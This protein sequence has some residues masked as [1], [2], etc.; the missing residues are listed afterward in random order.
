MKKTGSGR[1][2]CTPTFIAAL[3]TIDRTWKQ[4]KCPSTDQWV[5][6]A[7]YTYIPAMKYSS[8]TRKKEIL[9]F[10]TTWME[11]EGIML[12]EVNQTEKVKYCMM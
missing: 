7:I 3:L 12:S 4:P 2:I 1:D 6:I 10:V 9:T 8:A 5:D 11:V